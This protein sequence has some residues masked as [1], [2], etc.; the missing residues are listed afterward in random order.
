MYEKL[1]Y[2]DVEF[3]SR[4]LQYLEDMVSKEL[5]QLMG[6]SKSGCYDWVGDLD[7]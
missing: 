1:V 5:L 2:G 6:L 4:L 7:I 3:T